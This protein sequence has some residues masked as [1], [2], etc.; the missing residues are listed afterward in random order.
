VGSERLTSRKRTRCESGAENYDTTDEALASPRKT[1][2]KLYHGTSES[3]AKRILVEGI[4]PRHASGKS[5][6]KHSVES[7]PEAVYLTDAYPM[8]FANVASKTGERWA[9]IEVDTDRLDESKLHPDEDILEQCG[10]KYDG[11]PKT[12]DMKRRTRHYRKQ[13][14]N[15][16]N[17]EKSLEFMGTCGYYDTIPVKAITRV[18]YFDP[19]KYDAGMIL[20]LIDCSISLMNYRFCQTQ[21]RARTKWLMGE[22][23]DVKEIMGFVPPAEALTGEFGEMY[24][25]QTEGWTEMLQNRTGIE[26]KRIEPEGALV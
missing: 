19:K 22:C 7:N 4:K 14:I 8:Y 15:N 17:W 2:M 26:E 10:R 3:R 9:V 21:Y 12:W 18:V 16:P 1:F 25:K 24:R 5:N 11:L 6:W 13:A 23:D 20:S